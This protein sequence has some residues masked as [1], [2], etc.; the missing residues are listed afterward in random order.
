MPVLK[1]MVMVINMTNIARDRAHSRGFTIV[2]GM[3]AVALL[4][5]IGGA[6]WY[7]MRGKQD[8]STGQEN[9]KARDQQQAAAN[10]VLV[11][12]NLGLSS[13]EAVAIDTAAT[14][15]F[16]A[17]GHKGFYAFGD[18]L[19]GQPVRQNPNFEFSSLKEGTELIAAL[20]GVVGFIQ[21]QPESKDYEVFLMPS[22]NS[23]WVIGYDH[24][25]DLSVKKGDTVKVGQRIGKPARQNNGLLRFEIQINKGKDDAST[26]HICP[27]TLLADSVKSKVEAELKDM[28]D[29]WESASGLE[30]YD[31]AQQSPIG[32]I[33]QTLTPKEAQGIER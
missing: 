23:E 14:R 25:I 20:D 13:L 1:I 27:T 17:S 32:C 31:V 12:Q 24:V 30:L 21:E 28:Q 26:S 15:D 16:K 33:K 9:G 2:E 7:A 18:I 10:D 8:T 22:D 6:V 4:V 19:P 29:R 5:V 3:I 11:L